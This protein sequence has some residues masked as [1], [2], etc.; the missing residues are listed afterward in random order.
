MSSTSQTSIDHQRHT[1][2]HLLAHAVQDQ[3]PHV[4]FAIGPT[5]EDGFYY[6]FDL[7]RPLTPEDL[8]PLE[9]RIKH[10]IKQHL[11]MLPVDENATVVQKYVAAQPYKQE[12]I[13]DLRT[14]GETP[15]FYQI[16]SF[17]DLCRGGHASSTDEINP[18]GLML[19]RVAGAYWHGDST[20][21]MLQRVYGVAFATREEL[22]AYQVRLAEAEKRDH[23]KLGPALKLF[24]FHPT[25]PGMP[26]WLPNGVTLYNELLNFWRTEHV[27]HGYLE[28]TTPIINKKE[29]W[30][31]SG[32]WEHYR[33]DMFIA[34]MGE[35]EVYGLKAMNCPNAMIV[36]G[37]E[38]RSYRDLPL[39]LSDTDTLHRYEASGTL[40]GLLRV[41]S[42]RQDDSHNFVTFDQIESE[43]DAILK[44]ADRFYKIFKLD[45][46]LR[47][48]T[49]PEKFIGDR[50]SWDKAEAALKKI[51]DRRIGRGK[52]DVLDGDGAF[53]GPKIDILMKDSLGREWQ[54]GTIQLDFQLPKRFNLE[55]TT[56]DGSRQTPVVIHR[57][58]Y[59]SLERFLGILIEHFAGAFPLWLSPVQVQVVPV[60]TKHDALARR[61]T[62]LLSAAGIRAFHDDTTET[63]G[64]KIRRAEKGKIPYMVVIGDKEK[65]LRRVTV[66]VRSQKLPR[67]V[68]VSAW[69]K[70]L[71]KS[72]ANRSLAI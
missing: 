15:T 63:V 5:I 62:A 2:S 17:V 22:S 72:I 51:L 42:F 54:M 60:T 26:Y 34:D 65:G 48:G 28:I 47:L 67:Q 4:K 6:D 68:T 39:R 24:M 43:Y 53:Y 14:K 64:Y 12:L 3:F 71:Q 9:K 7:D 21:P 23:K 31:T 33:D 16:G 58:I 18:D 25:A 45:Y 35:H 38:S 50:P 19:T 41:R 36:Y 61:F 40:N 29:L 32:H 44:I 59:G 13:T 10:L 11:K 37:S 8:K 56:A 57:V 55:Y 69:I 66:R 70:T 46:R 52:Y 1:L 49:R 30:E 27:Q 20:K